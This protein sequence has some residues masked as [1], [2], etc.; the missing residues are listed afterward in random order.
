MWLYRDKIKLD[1]KHLSEIK[2]ILLLFVHRNIKEEETKLIFIPT[3][4]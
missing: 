1:N 2:K 3:A 4:L